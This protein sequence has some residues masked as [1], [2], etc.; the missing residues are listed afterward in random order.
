MLK[1][2]CCLQFKFNSVPCILSDNPIANINLQNVA[3]LLAC[4]VLLLDQ[5]LCSSP[6]G[7]P[8]LLDFNV[9]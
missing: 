4:N 7:M 3:L 6:S 2:I 1:I 5:T 9:I 8:E